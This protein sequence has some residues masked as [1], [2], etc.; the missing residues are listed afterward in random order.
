MDKDQ[1]ENLVIKKLRKT[2][3]EE[4]ENTTRKTYGSDDGSPCG[5]SADDDIAPESSETIPQITLPKHNKTQHAQTDR[6][7]RAHTIQKQ[8]KH[9]LVSGTLLAALR[10]AMLCFS[11]FSFSFFSF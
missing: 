7:A 6:D 9:T 8:T 5:T 3:S 2:I 1:N 10:F 4:K 11:S